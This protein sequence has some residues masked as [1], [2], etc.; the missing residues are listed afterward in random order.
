MKAVVV[1]RYGPVDGQRLADAPMPQPGEGE[2]RIRVAAA[3]I[4]FVDGLKIQGLYQTKDPLP[5]IPGMEFSGVVDALGS[6]VTLL[7]V[8]QRVLG[9]GL[10]GALAEFAVYP[11]A[12][13]HVVPVTVDLAQASGL[14]ANYTTALYALSET[15]QLRAGE[16]LLVLGASGGT[17]SAA[18]TLGK[19]LGARVIA[20][21][22][23]EAPGV[24]M[25]PI[26]T[27]PWN[28][29]SA[30]GA[31]TLSSAASGDGLA[32]SLTTTIVRSSTS[33]SRP[34]TGSVAV[35]YLLGSASNFALQP[36]LQKPISRPS[37]TVRCGVLAIS[38]VMPQTGSRLTAPPAPCEWLCSA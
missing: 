6:G 36:P 3:A 1:E 24:A 12:D 21:A 28:V 31:V 17:G 2:V 4:G 14:L 18:V 11:A 26:G 35:R 22:S 37:C 15:A 16:Q 33:E 29:A 5:F 8:G 30:S 27:G 9:L 23:T 25:P 13:L 38:T 10:R 20:A 32:T 34:V 7:Q 19:L